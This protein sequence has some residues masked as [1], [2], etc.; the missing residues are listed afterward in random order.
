MLWDCET[1][2]H[3]VLLSLSATFCNPEAAGPTGV[4]SILAHVLATVA[5]VVT[6][7]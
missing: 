1:Q 6:R 7:K 5:A 3:Q 2:A 4:A